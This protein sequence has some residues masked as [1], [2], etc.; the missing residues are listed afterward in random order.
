MKVKDYVEWRVGFVSDDICFAIVPNPGDSPDYVAVCF[1]TRE[2]NDD[3]INGVRFSEGF[4]AFL[5][6]AEFDKIAN[7]LSEESSLFGIKFTLDDELTKSEG[8]KCLLYYQVSEL[9]E[10]EVL[11]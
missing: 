8:L 5:C 6:K 1:S 9:S 11:V 3:G 4:R 7:L 2:S 10:S